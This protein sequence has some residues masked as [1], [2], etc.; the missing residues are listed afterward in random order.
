MEYDITKEV[1]VTR[2][3]L[4]HWMTVG[5]FWKGAFIGT[6]NARGAVV[7]KG[8]R[9]VN[10]P[11]DPFGVAIFCEGEPAMSALREN[12]ALAVA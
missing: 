11:R 7:V 1:T 12:V 3:L 9:V 8:F 6:I 5:L 2:M 4:D 10:Q